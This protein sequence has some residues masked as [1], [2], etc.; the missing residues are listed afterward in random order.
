MTIAFLQS[1]QIAS[2]DFAASSLSSW[3]AQNAPIVLLQCIICVKQSKNR[4]LWLHLESMYCCAI[5]KISARPDVKTHQKRIGRFS[6]WFKLQRFLN[7]FFWKMSPVLV[8]AQSCWTPM[9]ALGSAQYPSTRFKLNT[10]SVPSGA[11]LQLH[12]YRTSNK[13]KNKNKNRPLK[14]F[15]MKTSCTHI[16]IWALDLSVLDSTLPTDN[17]ANAEGCA[18]L[19]IISLNRM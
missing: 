19:W 10:V 11:D 16:Q 3:T 7:V 9:E 2:K 13:N 5:G 4:Q 1:C 17:T 8:P 12:V 15:C 18:N 6:Q 14:D